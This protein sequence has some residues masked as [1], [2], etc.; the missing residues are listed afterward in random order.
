MLSILLS[1]T[2]GYREEELVALMVNRSLLGQETVAVGFA[3]GLGSEF[4]ALFVVFVESGEVVVKC[5]VVVSLEDVLG[6]RKALRRR[7]G[8]SLV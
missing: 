4:L 2:G 1:V 8:R 3:D 5:M 7:V 6:H